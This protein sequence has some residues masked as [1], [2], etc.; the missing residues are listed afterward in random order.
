MDR[1]ESKRHG[2]KVDHV[3]EA[4]RVVSIEGQR[5]FVLELGAPSAFPVLFIHGGPDWDHS[6]LLP[7]A[8]TLA[9]NRR[10]VVFDLRGCGF[11]SVCED[12]EGYSRSAA[13]QD[14]LNLIPLVAPSEQ[15]HLL[16]FSFGGRLALRAAQQAPGKLASLI[17]ASTSLRG[18]PDWGVDSEE[19]R[20]RKNIVPKFEDVFTTPSLNSAQKTRIL[21]LESLPLDVWDLNVLPA[22]REH[23]SKIQFGGEWGRAWAAGLLAPEE[24]DDGEWLA[25]S[26]IPTLVIHGRH[27]FRFP[28]QDL[29]RLRHSRQTLHVQI[30][31]DA[32]HLAHLEKTKEWCAEVNAF[33]DLV[34]AG[35]G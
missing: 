30:I 4:N 28:V 2:G 8:R 32:G 9:V 13:T 23:I 17:L 20:Q 33:L 25:L 1:G 22:V 16:G 15:V 35:M 10:V 24:S 5:L 11:S 18:I 14:I 29:E 26:N 7:A 12:V 31:E 34:E 27:D 6:Y 3:V 19:R 21:A